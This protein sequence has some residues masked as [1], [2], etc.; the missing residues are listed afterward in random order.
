M[1]D[2]DARL[3]MVIAQPWRDIT[4]S[5]Q[6]L[7]EMLRKKRPALYVEIIA[8]AFHGSVHVIAV[9][10]ISGFDGDLVASF[11]IAE[12]ERHVERGA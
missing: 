6:M 1:L 7:A 5:V 11:A 10:R 2:D 3:I 12:S 8:A 9:G 4:K